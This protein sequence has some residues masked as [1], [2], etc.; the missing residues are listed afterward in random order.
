MISL[1]TQIFQL[2]KIGKG[3][4]HVNVFAGDNYKIE[5]NHCEYG[6]LERET[7]SRY[8]GA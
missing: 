2:I 4:I 3:S 1:D 5:V 8:D 6:L 7:V